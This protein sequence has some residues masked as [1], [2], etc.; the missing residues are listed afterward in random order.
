MRKR[1]F[2]GLPEKA[3]SAQKIYQ[4]NRVQFIVHQKHEHE[5]PDIQELRNKVQILQGVWLRGVRDFD[6]DHQANLQKPGHP[7]EDQRG[8]VQSQG[9][10]HQIGPFAKHQLLSH[11]PRG[12]GIPLQV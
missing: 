9:E 1:G 5:V 11:P 6:A 3:E 10:G 7:A 2:D 8:G 4:Q 12:Q